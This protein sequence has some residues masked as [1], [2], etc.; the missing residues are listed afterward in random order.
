M[1]LAAGMRKVAAEPAGRAT[2]D[3][4]ELALGI[5]S[6]H[7]R[8]VPPS[9]IGTKVKGPV[10]VLYYRVVGP[11]LIEIVRVLHERM[12]PTQHIDQNQ[13]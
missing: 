10:H 3:R 1:L 5:R 7:L 8:R 13:D 9:K 12:E 6:F 11:S 2:R 4:S